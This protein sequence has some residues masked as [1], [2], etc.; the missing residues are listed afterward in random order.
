MNRIDILKLKDIYCLKMRTIENPMNTPEMVDQIRKQCLDKE[1]ESIRLDGEFTAKGGYVYREYRDSHP[2]TIEPFVIPEEKGYLINSIDP[3]D[4]TPHG[5]WWGWVDTDG[6]VE[7]GDFVTPPLRNGIPRIYGVRELFEPG[8][9]RELSDQIKMVELD[10][11]READMRLCD[12][13]SWNEGQ[14]ENR[15]KTTFDLFGEYGI[16][17]IKGS[18]DMTGGNR[19]VRIMLKANKDEQESD[20]PDLILFTTMKRL[21]WE[22]VNYRYPD[23]RGKAQAERK[24]PDKPIDKDDH[25]IECQRRGCE[26][27]ENG[28]LYKTENIDQYP[29]LLPSGETIHATFDDMAFDEQEIDNTLM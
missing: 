29:A 25:I 26:F 14:T 23:W 28:D 10:L 2:W 17:V 5:V 6:E 7:C 20:V 27:V 4:A 12:P 16:H 13:S 18:K 24:R 22:M 21:R 15:T 11:G 1:E 19:K 3:H 8:T 9:I